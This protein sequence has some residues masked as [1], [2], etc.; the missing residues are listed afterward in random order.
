M[1][2]KGISLPLKR[3]IDERKTKERDYCFNGDFQKA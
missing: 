3:I 1:S 2:F